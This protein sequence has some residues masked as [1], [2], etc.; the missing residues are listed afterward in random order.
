MTTSLPSSLVAPEAERLAQEHYAAAGGVK[1]WDSLTPDQREWWAQ[2]HAALLANLERPESRDAWVRWG[3]RRDTERIRARLGEEPDVLDLYPVRS[4]W[5][6][7][8]DDALALR[9]ALIAMEAT[10]G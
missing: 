8:R 6:A 2:P 5:L 4:R 10:N 7:L 1:P 9:A 3:V